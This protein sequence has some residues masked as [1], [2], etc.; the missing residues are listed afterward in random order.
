MSSAAYDE[1]ADWYEHEFLTDKRTADDDP[2][3]INRALVELLGTGS[4]PCLEIGCGTGINAHRIRDLGWIPVGVDLSTGMLRYAS[5]RLPTVQGDATRLPIQD[6]SM[7]AVI[8]VMIHTDL[9]DY[10]AVLREVRRVLQPGGLFVHIGVHPCFCGGFADPSDP[11]AIVI[12]PGYLTGHW[13]TD[14]WTD[15]GVRARI[16]ATHLPLSDLL[17][18]FVDAG[19][20]LERFTEGGA[21]TPTTLAIRAR[22]TST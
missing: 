14:S 7:L 22:L 3:G 9:P 1:I 16:G 13:T 17:H 6:Q 18:T 15:Q 19:L 5:G 20:H 21:I 11:A 4:G 8:A 2:L 12:R 10:P